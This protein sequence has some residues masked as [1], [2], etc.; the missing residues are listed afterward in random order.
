[1]RQFLT[2][3]FDDGIT[4]GG[5]QVSSAMQEAVRPRPRR[6][7]WCGALLIT[8]LWLSLAISP[9]LTAQL[10]NGSLIGTVADAAGKVVTNSSVTLTNLG[11][12]EKKTT[13]TDSNGDYQFLFLIP[14][15]YQVDI[16]KTGFSKFSLGSVDIKVQTA[17]RVDAVLQIG[18]V[19]QTV[20]VSSTTGELLQTQSATLGTTVEGGQ[21]QSMPLNGRN[22]MNLVALAPGVVPQGTSMT[23]ILNNQGGGTNPAGWNNYQ[24]GGAIAGSNS[25]YLD[26]V[27]LN[28]IG[29]NPSWSAFTPTQD[30]IQ[31][32][33]VETNSV[34]PAFGRFAGGVIVFSTKS[35]TNQF[36]GNA[37]EFL[38]NTVFDANNF[39]L[40]RS[41]QPRTQLNQNQYGIF[42]GGPVV[43]KKLFF[44][45]S[46]EGYQQRAGQPILDVVPTADQLT[47]NFTGRATITDPQTGQPF[48]NN[49][50]P[51]GRIDPTANAIANTIKFWP[52]PNTSEPGGNFASSGT[53]GGKSNQ[54]NTRIDWT[55]SD[56]QTVF[57]R[58]TF[59]QNDTT[60]EDSF[61]IGLPG[62]GFQFNGPTQQL[63]LGDTYTLS[64]TTVMEIRASGTLFKFFI[65]NAAYGVNLSTLGPNW[66]ALAPQ[67]NYSQYPFLEI[68]G[69]S[70]IF[71][72]SLVEDTKSTNETLSG[73][74]T[75]IIGRHTI[76]FGGE[77]RLLLFNTGEANCGTLCVV[78]S[79]AATGDGFASFLLGTPVGGTSSELQT[80]I[81]SYAYNRYQGYYVGDT[82]QVTPRLT[83]NYGL[84][85][86]LPGGIGER[87]NRNTVFLPNATDPL[88]SVTGLSLKGQLALVGSSQYSNRYGTDLHYHLFGPRV[89]FSWSP[90]KDNVVRGGYGLSY[91]PIENWIEYGTPASAP[92]GEAVTYLSP[93]STLSNPFPSGVNHPTGSSPNFM[94]GLE[95]GSLI[96]TNPTSPFGYSQQWNLGI[97]HQ[98]GASTMLDVAYAGSKGTDLTNSVNINQLPDSDDSMGA[99]LL[100]QISPNPFAGNV[101]VTSELN[102]SFTV[103]QSL[104]PDP[105]FL[106]ITIYNAPGFNTIY[107][108]FQ[109]EVQKQFGSSGKLLAAYTWSKFIGNTDGITGYLESNPT[110]SIQDN[111]NLKAERS[112]MSFDTPQRF[113]AGYVLG[114]PF[115][116]N[117]RWFS[118]V[119]GI[120]SRI[121][122]GWGVDG[123]TVFQSGFP[124]VMTYAIPT[125]LQ[126]SFGAGAPRPNVVAGCKKS[127]GGSAVSRISEWFNT[128]CFSAPS[129]FG[130]GNEGRTDST[131]RGQGIDNW[132]LSGSK[133]TKITEGVSL[134]FRGEIFNLFNRVQ[135]A[136]PGT[137]YNPDTLNTPGNTFGVLTS[138]NNPP[139]QAQFVLRLKF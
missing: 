41:N 68:A 83:L 12:L 36:H 112:L 47:G 77:G 91:I 108:S 67:L 135:F 84:R 62:E 31:E 29:N 60:P 15:Q 53:Y 74:L 96:S 61:H 34:D 18:A 87:H 93:N 133:E 132:D 73:S 97:E 130:F 58:Y 71:Y 27:P 32:F 89:G 16:E 72:Q 109:A 35:G 65:H 128:S 94:P 103:G 138:Q 110:G 107:H 19:Q 99:Q 7:L 105:Q 119:N 123:I 50:I 129:T 69:Y 86:E 4:C 114:L 52:A 127:L 25:S 37:Y 51:P 121:I 122:S 118:N 45:S 81:P 139:R 9:T 2:G 57:G 8:A 42:A 22:V 95:G 137:A 124:L 39:F 49:I 98:F 64:P 134:E 66:G 131:L 102:S 115:G 20:N 82:F 92:V 30:A 116:Q 85:W 117:Q 125:A 33:K 21:V 10:V 14:G 79:S 126:S 13:R 26:G 17:T 104:L 120:T 40:N 46:W 6:R 76:R 3:S 55:V 100:T 5:K 78:F 24:I 1:M 80:F 88:S 75:K 48:P 11:T 111:D 44:F 63:A 38:R 28:I 54:Y 43:R 136:P 106:N 59:W 56:K 101:P 113:V 70:T 90:I 23:T